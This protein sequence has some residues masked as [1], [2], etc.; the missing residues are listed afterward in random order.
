MFTAGLVGRFIAGVYSCHLYT[1]LCLGFVR[2]FMGGVCR[3]VYGYGIQE[4][5]QMG[6]VRRF[7]AEVCRKAK[8]LFRTGNIYCFGLYS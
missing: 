6:F 7:S 4:D 1:S 8:G 2:W 5:L 3:A